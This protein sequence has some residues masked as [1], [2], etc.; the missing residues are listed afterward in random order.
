MASGKTF[1]E[2]LPDQVDRI[3]NLSESQLGVL[4]DFRDVYKERAVLEKD[5][6]TKMALLTKKASDR[7]NK[8]MASLVVG[9]DPATAWGDDVIRQSTLD[10]AYTQLIAS[11]D[12]TA[13]DHNTL[14][15]LLISQVADS[16]KALEKKH[17]DMRKKQLQFYQKTLSDR[18]KVY[19]ERLK[20]KQKYDEECL[21]VESFRQKQ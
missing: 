21:E 3:A 17:E 13:Q 15:D 16:T 6:A 2:N 8:R 7:K 20:C 14:S 18:D 11:L 12:G 4:S 9:D 10:N 1:G 19:A 5:Y